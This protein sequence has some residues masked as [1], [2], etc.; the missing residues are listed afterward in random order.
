MVSHLAMIEFTYSVT[1]SNHYGA[2]VDFVHGVPRA[3]TVLAKTSSFLAQATRA[4]L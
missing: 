2:T 3:R 4:T 1:L